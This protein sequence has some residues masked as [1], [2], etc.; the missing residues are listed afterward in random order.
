MSIPT[1][2]KPEDENGTKSV[3]NGNQD[4][5]TGGGWIYRTFTK[6]KTLIVENINGHT[7][8]GIILRL[9]LGCILNSRNFSKYP[10]VAEAEFYSEVGIPL[11]A[12]IIEAIGRTL[13]EDLLGA[14]LIIWCG[15]PKESS[16]ALTPQGEHLFVM[17]TELAKVEPIS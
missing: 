5:V 10:A 4:I 14:D 2:E 16:I 11:K 6:E 12:A 15:D 9:A 3:P 13:Y 8:E 1:D 7:Y 17:L